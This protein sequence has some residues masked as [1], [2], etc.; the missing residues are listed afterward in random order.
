[1]SH[2]L[3]SNK[4]LPLKILA[5]ILYDQTD[6]TL[7]LL[8]LLILS[9]VPTYKPTGETEFYSMGN[10]KTDKLTSM[11]MMMLLVK[12]TSLPYS[13]LGNSKAINLILI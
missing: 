12:Q 6:V 7:Y 11:M 9:Q 13:V 1:M 10:I 2:I 3:C 8:Y 4:T 5:Q